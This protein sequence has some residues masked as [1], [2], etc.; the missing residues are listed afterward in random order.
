MKNY[1]PIRKGSILWIEFQSQISGIHQFSPKV[2]I[3]PSRDLKSE[4]S[5]SGLRVAD[6]LDY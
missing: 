6:D 1:Q 4:T 5:V 3:F 2:A